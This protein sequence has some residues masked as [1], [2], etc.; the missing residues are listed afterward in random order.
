M[1]AADGQDTL[2]DIDNYASTTS[3]QLGADLFGTVTAFDSSSEVDINLASATGAADVVNIGLL[4]TDDQAGTIDVDAAGAEVLNIAVDTTATESHT[5]NLAGV[6]ATT[7]ENVAINIT[8]GV[9]T[10]GLIIADVAATTNVINAADFDGT[11]T[12]SQRGSDAMTITGGSAADNL[13]MENASDVMTGGAGS[14][15]L[16]IAHNSILGGMAVDLSATTGDQL[17]T[18][19]GSAN[20]AVQSGFENVDLSNMTGSGGADITA[21]ASGST[22]TGTVNTDQVTLHSTTNITDVVVFATSIINGADTIVNFDAGTGA[23][24][25]DLDV[26]AVTASADFDTAG[27]NILATTG[28]VVLGAAGDAVTGAFTVAKALT[29]LAGYDAQITANDEFVFA[30]DNGTDTALFYFSDAD[31]GG[32]ANG[33]EAVLLATLT[34]VADATDIVTQNVIL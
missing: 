32:D 16:T 19:N 23:T 7:D 21:S 10:D 14:D 11:L 8:G 20:A 4:D 6:T 13:R 15:T 5:L 28:F 3:I 1:A 24:D 22:I 2:L 25:D 29:E 31:G 34:G 33:S 26:S 27:A 12:V 17:A 18:F 9:S 30:V